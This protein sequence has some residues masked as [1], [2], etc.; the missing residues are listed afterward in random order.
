MKRYLSTAVKLCTGAAA[1]AAT[2]IG[3]ATQT[4][5]FTLNEYIH[6][7]KNQIITAAKDKKFSPA[8]MKEIGETYCLLQ[9]KLRD[10][11]EDEKQKTAVQERLDL[12][13]KVISNFYEKGE[14]DVFAYVGAVEEG[15]MV[16]NGGNVPMPARLSAEGKA[17][18]YQGSTAQE[19][20]RKQAELLRR[21][22]TE[23]K[24]VQTDDRKNINSSAWHRF[25]IEVDS[26]IFGKLIDE[27]TDKKYGGRSVAGERESEWTSADHAQY[28][29]EDKTEANRG[30]TTGFGITSDEELP[31]NKELEELITELAKK[32][33]KC[34]C[35]E[36]DKEKDKTE[37]EKGKE[38]KKE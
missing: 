29:G 11:I 13:G 21:M 37:E 19:T 8:E 16:N 33:H 10:G 26:S 7:S 35:K 22:H 32:K 1:Y 15:K 2:V 31:V 20:T 27:T 9:D 4:K 25:Y 38:D 6:T 23:W 30:R 17:Q 36:D 3:C 28:F 34:N 12:L 5:E 14:F 18:L 24:S